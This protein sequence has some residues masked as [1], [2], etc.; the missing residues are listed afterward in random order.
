[1]YPSVFCLFFVTS[2]AQK[3][4]QTKE[5]PKGWSELTVLDASVKLD[6]RYATTNNFMKQQV[7]DC[8]RC[9]L[10]ADVAKAVIKAHKMLQKKGFGLKMFDCYRPRPVQFKL[11]AI[12]PDERYV[13][14][15]N[16]GSMHNRGMAVDLTIVDKDGNELDMGTGF[17]D[18]TPKAHVTYTN[19]PKKVLENRELLTQTM[20][21]CGFRGTSTEWW[22]FSYK[23]ALRE[24]ADWLWECR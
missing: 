20:E 19:L 22:H 4:K 18:F 17:D 14:N 10:Q 5:V 7:Y 23:G 6:L 9:F 24:L 21:A 1:M 2:C 15:P 3:P 8:G 12:T 13:A 11:W 16:K